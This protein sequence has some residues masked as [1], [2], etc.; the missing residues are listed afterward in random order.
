MVDQLWEEGGLLT[1]GAVDML[2]VDQGVE[3]DQ[4]EDPEAM[5]GEV[6]GADRGAAT[7]RTLM[8]QEE[9]QGLV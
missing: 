6:Q 5:L 1:E 9:P 7:I 4:G 2:A 3:R 8:D